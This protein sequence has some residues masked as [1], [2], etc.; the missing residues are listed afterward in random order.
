MAHLPPQQ[1]YYR[2]NV[3]ANQCLSQEF[4]RTQGG[5]VQALHWFSQL[6]P[7]FVNEQTWAQC[8]TLFGE[9]FENVVYH[10]QELTIEHSSVDVRVKMTADMIEVQVWD[11]GPGFDFDNRLKN[12]P[13]M[14]SVEAERGRGLWI[15]AQVADHLSYTRESDGRNCLKIKKSWV[16]K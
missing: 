2:S 11:S 1:T 9:A 5:Y 15:M 3:P 16:P 4:E 8:I 12:L 7:S 13:E 14:I 6:R 10:V